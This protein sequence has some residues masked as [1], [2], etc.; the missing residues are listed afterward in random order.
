MLNVKESRRV[1]QILAVERL[2]PVVGEDVE[3]ACKQVK[4][5]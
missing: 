1:E 4:I 2:V 3:K 5:T